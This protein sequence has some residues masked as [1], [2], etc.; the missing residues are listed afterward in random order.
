MVSIINFSDEVQNITIKAD[1]LYGKFEDLLKN[2]Y[3]TED[4]NGKRFV[5]EPFEYKLFSSNSK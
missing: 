5:L 3:T 4:L 2:G 1:E